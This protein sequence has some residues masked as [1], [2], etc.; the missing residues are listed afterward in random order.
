MTEFLE[1]CM[2]D[3]V[4]HILFC[5]FILFILTLIKYEATLLQAN[6]TYQVRVRAVNSNGVG[7]SSAIVTM[8]TPCKLTPLDFIINYY[9]QH[10]RVFL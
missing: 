1:T 7:A 4:Q 6:T 2:L 10:L 9:I 5:E 3:P 8:T